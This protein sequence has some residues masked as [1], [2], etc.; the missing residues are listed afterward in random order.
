MNACSTPTF[1]SKGAELDPAGL[2]RGAALISGHAP[3]NGG[4]FTSGTFHTDPRGTDVSMQASAG[5]SHCRPRI[6]SVESLYSNSNGTYIL[7]AVLRAVPPKH[8]LIA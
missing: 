2:A 7:I 3:L 4:D 6:V 1:A 5:W 8:A